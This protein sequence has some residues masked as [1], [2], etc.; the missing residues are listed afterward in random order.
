MVHKLP[1]ADTT[2]RKTN[3]QYVLQRGFLSPFLP[4]HT[5]K[6]D[7]ICIVHLRKLEG[8]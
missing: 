5:E 3:N 1:I 4:W 8:I 6:K 7:D 2:K